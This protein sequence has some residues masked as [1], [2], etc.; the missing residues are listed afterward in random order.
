MRPWV[1]MRAEASEAERPCVIDV[2]SL[3]AVSCA[4]RREWA[5][6]IDYSHVSATS[7][8][9]H[10]RRGGG[11]AWRTEGVVLRLMASGGCSMGEE[12]REDLEGRPAAL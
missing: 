2:E 1:C 11:S 5:D 9:L 4:E 3:W 7:P 10:S 6:V 8:K 12:G